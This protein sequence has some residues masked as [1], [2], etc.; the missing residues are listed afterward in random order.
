MAKQKMGHKKTSK[1]RGGNFLPQAFGDL[2]N[3]A[4]NSTIGQMGFELLLKDEKIKK[5]IVMYCKSL[6]KIEQDETKKFNDLLINISFILI[7]IINRDDIS[8]IVNNLQLE[9][10]PPVGNLDE[11]KFSRVKQFV[12]TNEDMIRKAFLFFTEKADCPSQRNE[13]KTP[14]IISSLEKVK[15]SLEESQTVERDEIVTL[16]NALIEKKDQ[17]ELV[18]IITTG[19]INTSDNSTD[20]NNPF[21]IA[22]FNGMGGRKSAKKRKYRKKEV[23]KRKTKK[24]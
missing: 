2:A 14:N 3:V 12:A 8:Y 9:N 24:T 15:M 22:Q 5:M 4:L 17:N 6:A 7:N 20:T 23:R 16:I 11:T 18:T 19:K 13:I 1:K 10:P 21:N